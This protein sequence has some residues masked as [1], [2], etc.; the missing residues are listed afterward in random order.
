MVLAVRPRKAALLNSVPLQEI[1]ER[2]NAKFQN[3]AS[4]RWAILNDD[5]RKP[6]ATSTF[7]F[8]TYIRTTT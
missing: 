1:Y 3:P 5:R 7:V 6:R 4:R 2:W 8:V